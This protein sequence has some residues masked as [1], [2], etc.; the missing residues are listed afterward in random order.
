VLPAIVYPP[1]QGPWALNTGVEVL[2]VGEMVSLAVAYWAALRLL[3]PRYVEPGEGVATPKQVVCFGF[4]LLGLLIAEGW[5]LS[6]IANNYLYSAHMLQHL[7]FV[8]VIPPLFL[9]G[10]PSW[11]VR[12]L[13]HRPGVFPLMKRITRPVQATII[14]NVVLVGSHWPALV[15]LTLHN[16]GIHVADHVLLFA[17]GIVMWWPVLSPLPELPRLSYPA[18]MIYLFVQTIVPTIPASF[19]TFASSPL[20]HFY[21]SVPRAFGISALDDTRIS[22]LMMKLG[23]AMELW[24]IIAVIFFRWSSQEERKARPPDVLEWQ[25]V[26][27]ELNLSRTEPK[28][29]S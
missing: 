13:V 27:R 6:Q 7:I 23:M 26:E 16:Q 12:V 21:E 19:L 9:L 14:F 18:Q 20:Y 4:G 22:G 11:L 29:P 15:N 10:T 17:A 2:V 3:G 1:G 25:A 5:P 28:N 8:L 24:S